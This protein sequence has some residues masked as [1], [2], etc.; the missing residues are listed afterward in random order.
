MY[1]VEDTFMI[2]MHSILLYVHCK[3]RIEKSEKLFISQIA[4]FN[5]YCF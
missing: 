5:I 3:C 4:I 2:I 1:C